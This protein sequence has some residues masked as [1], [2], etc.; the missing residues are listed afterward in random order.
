M[1]EHLKER[2]LVARVR[3]RLEDEY[4]LALPEER[5]PIGRAADGSTRQHRFDLVGAEREFVGTVRTYALGEGSG[6]PSGKFAHCYA[7][8][9]FLYRVRARRRILVL[10]DRAFWAR[11][12]RESD[13]VVE[14][15]EVIHV[16]VDED[17][18]IDTDLPDE[19]PAAPPRRPPRGPSPSRPPRR[20]EEVVPP[21]RN[22]GGP[23]PAG[24]HPNTGPRRRDAGS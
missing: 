8:C 11:F 12:R 5:V 17:A 19:E 14:G 24:R 1:Q 13:G 23:G 4:G 20:G 21:R 2:A 22:R 7:A 18:P 10:T 9:L 3:G 15:I 16:P 6:R